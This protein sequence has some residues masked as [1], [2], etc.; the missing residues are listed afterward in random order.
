M[1]SSTQL[2][3]PL[4]LAMIVAS[5]LLVV[6]CGSG[7][8]GGGGGGG[9]GG[10][11][12]GPVLTASFQSIQTNIFSVQCEFCHTGATAPR[13]LRL[14]AANSFGLLVGVPS[15]QQPALQRVEPGN[16][17]DSYLIRKLEGGPGISGGQMPLGLPALPQSDI[18]VIRQWISDG[19][20]PTPAPPPTAPIRVSSMSPLPDSDQAML[21]T[22]VM[23]MFDRE[24]NASTIDVTTFLVERSGGDGTFGDGNE[25]AIVPDSVTVPGANPQSAVANISSTQ[26]IDDRYRVTLVGTGPAVILDLDGNALDGEFAGTFPSGDDTEGGDFIAEFNV[27]GI[28][29]TLTSI[30]DNVFTMTCSGC[31]TGSGANLPGSMDLTSVG[32]SFANLVSVASIQEPTLERVTP[33]DADNSYLIHKLEG[34]DA[35]GQ[36]IAT[37]QM[38]PGSPLDQNTIDVIRQWIDAGAS[39]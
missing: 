28:Q 30:Q 3:A 22:T 23:V 6:S 8:G 33:S 16:P 19:A 14:D 21:P 26:S 5:S 1:T 10:A 36:P 15:S 32:D 39:M 2:P 13:G 37:N 7:S 12:T 27:V 29:P 24:V 38:P 11:G 34:V 25:I 20:L 31:H 17:D 4:G 35:N 9:G 18:D